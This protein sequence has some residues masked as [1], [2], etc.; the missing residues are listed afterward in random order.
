MRSALMRSTDSALRPS[1][2]MVKYGLV[3]ARARVVRRATVVP[4]P[5]RRLA[6]SRR[7]RGSLPALRRLDREGQATL[8]DVAV[9]GHDAVAHGVPAGR[10]LS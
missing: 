8:D 10:K 5:V 9:D 2:R 6:R 3:S 1:K 7:L 4:R